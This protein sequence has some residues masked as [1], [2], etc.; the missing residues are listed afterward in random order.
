[1]QAIVA[2][3]RAVALREAADF[4]FTDD[5]CDCGGCDSCV[6]NKMAAELRRRADEAADAA[7][8]G[9]TSAEERPDIQVWPLGRVLSEVRCGSQDWSWGEE[10]ADLDYYRSEELAALEQQIR[11]NGITEPLLIGTDGRLWNGH[12]RLRLAVRLNIVYVPVRAAA[13]RLPS[14][15][16][17]A[18]AGGMS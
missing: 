15:S 13:G 10:W 2:Q 17:E 18:P 7:R 8:T 16:V 6:P 4:V 1:M 14:P 9:Q 3:A 12:H 5:D 11:V